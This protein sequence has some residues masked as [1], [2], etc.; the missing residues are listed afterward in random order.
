MTG[1]SELNII[2]IYHRQIKALSVKSQEA[3]RTVKYL[4]GNP[5]QHRRK[6]LPFVYPGANVMRPSKILLRFSKVR[7]LKKNGVF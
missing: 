2:I 1:S 5:D 3:L 6:I 7:K 4:T